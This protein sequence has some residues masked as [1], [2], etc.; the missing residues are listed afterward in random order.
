MVSLGLSV[1]R[2]LGLSK[3]TGIG[4]EVGFGFLVVD[5][6]SLWWTRNAKLQR[7][8]VRRLLSNDQRLLFLLQEAEA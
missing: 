1:D 2:E 7:F 5:Q 6:G 3:G 4:V 8:S